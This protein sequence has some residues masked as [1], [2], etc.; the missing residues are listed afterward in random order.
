MVWMGRRADLG[1]GVDVVD[2]DVDFDAGT[3][4]VLSMRRFCRLGLVLQPQLPSAQWDSACWFH[5]FS[6]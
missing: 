5:L 6:S 4:R 2:V 3:V 1:D